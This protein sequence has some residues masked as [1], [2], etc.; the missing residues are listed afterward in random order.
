MLEI[1]L[2]LSFKCHLKLDSRGTWL[3]P[4]VEH[5]TYFGPSHDLQFMISCPKLGSMLGMEST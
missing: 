1:K 5:L 3:A 4:S 2:K